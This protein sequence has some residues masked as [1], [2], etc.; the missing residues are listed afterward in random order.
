MQGLSEN[1]ICDLDFL[2]KYL[3]Y[4]PSSRATAS[5][6]GVERVVGVGRG[7][8]GVGL[9]TTATSSEVCTQCRALTCWSSM[10]SSLS[11]TGSFC[12]SMLLVAVRFALTRFML[13]ASFDFLS[14]GGLKNDKLH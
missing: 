7:G 3:Y 9:Q 1:H 4:N 14:G 2:L 5:L 11:S 6:P 12:S 8:G 10:T 13:F